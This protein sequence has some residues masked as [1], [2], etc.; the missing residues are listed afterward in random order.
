MYPLM[1]ARFTLF[2]RR[3]KQLELLFLGTGAGMPAK[4]RNVASFALKLLEE[5]NAVWLFDCGEATQH[6]ILYTSLKPKK[7]EKIFISHLHGDHIY[8]LP[9]LLS[10]RSVQGG[11]SPLVIY[12]PTGIEAFVKTSLLVSGTKLSYSLEIVEI[13]EG[14]IF[15]DDQFT[16]MAKKVSHGIDSYGYRV[17][18][19][20]LPGALL[21]DALIQKGIRPGPVYQRLK[22]GETIETENGEKINGNDFMG[23]AKKGRIVAYTGD[24][25]L[26]DS[27]C[28]LAQDADVLIHEATFGKEEDELARLYYHSTTEHAAATAKKANVK[29]LIL[30]HISARYQGDAKKKELE[31]EAKTIFPQTVVASDFDSYPIIRSKE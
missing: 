29:Q 20:D 15:Q 11:E 6:Q 30:T 16:V 21:V 17:E 5:R 9:G 19:K 14:T 24:T 31:E 7:I 1:R 12:G 10:S 23:P 3:I 25:R 2:L 13:E 18:E 8:G 22:N 26:C 27:L 28:E 4:T